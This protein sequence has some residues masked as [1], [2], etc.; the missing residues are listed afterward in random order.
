VRGS[1]GH[2]K[3]F[4]LRLPGRTENLAD[5]IRVTPA[6]AEA[7]LRRFQADLTDAETSSSPATEILT[8]DP[9]TLEIRTRVLTALTREAIFGLSEDGQSVRLKS[10]RVIE[11]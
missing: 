11:R 1:N 4:E 10:L 2:W 7:D 3:L 9:A 5:F 8:F 6:L